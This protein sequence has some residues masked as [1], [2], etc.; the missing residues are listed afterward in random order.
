MADHPVHEEPF[1]C[2]DSLLA[3]VQFATSP[4]LFQ[5][6]CSPASHPPIYVYNNNGFL[7]K[8]VTNALLPYHLHFWHHLPRSGSLQALELHPMGPRVLS[9]DCRTR[10]GDWGQP[11][12]LCAPVNLS[13]PIKRA[14]CTHSKI[15]TCSQKLKGGGFS[16]KPCEK[17]ELPE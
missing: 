1:G 13:L 7:H 11:E 14:S 4:N 16:W 6:S 5:Q 10:K 12:L 15:I 8:W 9:Q 2:Q 17:S 3:H